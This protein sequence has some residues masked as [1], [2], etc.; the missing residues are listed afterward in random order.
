M[1]KRAFVAALILPVCAWAHVYSGT[2]SYYANGQDIK[3]VLSS[4]ARSQG[5]AC[6]MD[7]AVRARVSGNF[8]KVR[9]EDFL[10]AMREAYGLGVYVAGDAMH[11]YK[12]SD[13]RKE[14]MTVPSGSAEA[15]LEECTYVL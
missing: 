6:E 13:V 4:F 3:T 12:L 14:F 10:E 7:S 9:P 8:Q 11:V 15:L 1:L 5:L 2:F